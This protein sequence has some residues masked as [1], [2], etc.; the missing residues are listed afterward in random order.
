MFKGMFKKTKYVPISMEE[1]QQ[2][3]ADQLEPEVRQQEQENSEASATE[4]T[5]DEGDQPTV[6]E[7][8]FIK[9]KIC[10]KTIYRP[11][12]EENLFVCPE[13]GKYHRVYAKSRIRMIIDEGTFE[14]W[15]GRRGLPT[16]CIFRDIPRRLKV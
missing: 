10:R 13:C 2:Q 3:E 14:Q 12:F 5:E 16:R 4:L 8:L 1:T 7:G 9:C 11:D 6:P 15:D